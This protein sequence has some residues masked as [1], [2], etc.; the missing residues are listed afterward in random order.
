[1]ADTADILQLHVETGGVTQFQHGRRCKGKYHRILDLQQLAHGATGHGRRLL[2]HVLAQ[3]PVFQAHEGDT[4]VLAVTAEAETGHGKHGRDVVFLAVHEVVFDLFDHF[5][6]ALLRGARRQLNLRK[7]DALVFFR[8][9]GGRQAHEDE[10]QAG[11]QQHVQQHR[12]GAVRDHGANPAL[13]LVAAAVEAAVEPAE[14]TLVGGVVAF[15]DRL[16]QGGT[17][18]WRKYQRDDDGQHHR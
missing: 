4:R 5:Q 3:R 10:H 13:V 17:Q 1:M 16:E 15:F 7:Q 2:R 12:A 6:G 18:G 9:E 8:Q 11:E 14:E